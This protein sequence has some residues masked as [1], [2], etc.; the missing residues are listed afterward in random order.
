MI[1]NCTLILLN[2]FILEIFLMGKINA[3]GDKNFANIAE[4]VILC[5]NDNYIKNSNNK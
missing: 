3:K 2:I 1:E 4:V 5:D